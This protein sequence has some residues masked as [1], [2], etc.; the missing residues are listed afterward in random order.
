MMLDYAW[1]YKNGQLQAE[2][3]RTLLSLGAVCE[4]QVFDQF[5]QAEAMS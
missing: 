1:G 2:Q 3:A 5:G 4:Q